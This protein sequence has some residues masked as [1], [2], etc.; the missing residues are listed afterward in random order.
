[1]NNPNP[2]VWDWRSYIIHYAP[3]NPTY[4]HVLLTLSC[5]MDSAGGSCFPSIK[6]LSE[7]T[8]LS[9]PSVIK[10]LNQAESD[11]WIEK[12]VHGFSGQGWKRHEYTASIPEKVVNE[13]NHVGSKGGKPH[14]EGGKA[15]NKGGKADRG[16]VVN[17][18]NTISSVNSSN[19]SPVES[20]SEKPV[21]EIS[22]DALSLVSFFWEC[23]SEAN[24]QI[25]TKP[26]DD[27]STHFQNLIDEGYNVN[28]IKQLIEALFTLELEPCLFYRKHVDDPKSFEKHARKFYLQIRS[29]YT[30]KKN[31]PK[32]RGQKH[33]DFMHYLMED[34]A[35]SSRYNGHGNTPDAQ[36]IA[37]DVDELFKNDPP[38]NY[39]SRYDESALD[40]Y[41]PQNN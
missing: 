1:M 9:K 30:E 17:Q 34:Q 6:K 32:T 26:N 4:R 12:S 24:P 21:L 18:V 38:K 29:A 39:Q 8:S 40:N 27:Q 7:C 13:I 31:K 41:K 28:E 2:K 23:F 16:K 15:E 14:N 20:S 5:F 25:P 35:H 3:E 37:E 10:Y 22:E 11:G 19:N 36:G 33:S